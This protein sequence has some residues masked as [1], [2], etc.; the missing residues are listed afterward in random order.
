MLEDMKLQDKIDQINKFVE[1]LE[2]NPE[3]FLLEDM[4]QLFYRE[5]DFDYENFSCDKAIKDFRVDNGSIS[6]FIARNQSMNKAEAKK[7]WKP[8]KYNFNRKNPMC[9]FIRKYN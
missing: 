5:K 8:E 4:L 7:I 6:T 1:D 3:M 9:D 2:Q